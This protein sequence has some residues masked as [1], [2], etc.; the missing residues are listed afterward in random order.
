MQWD[1][2]HAEEPPQNVEQAPTTEPPASLLNQFNQFMFS[3]LFFD[4]LAGHLQ[5][6]G[7]AT[8]VPF[9]VVVLIFGGVFFT[10]WY[11]FINI[12]GFFHSITITRGKYDNKNDHGEITHFRALASALSATVGLGNIAGVAVAIQVGGP[13]VI[14]WMLCA[15][16]FGMSLKFSECTLAQMYRRVNADGSISGGPMYY[17]DLG[18]MA[19]GGLFKPFGKILAVTFAIMVMGGAIGGGNM[20]QANQSFEALATVLGHPEWLAA[21]ST[22]SW[23]FG[24]ILAFAVALVIIGGIK[25]IGAASSYIVPF[26]CGL[27]VIF[28]LFIIGSNYQQIPMA[29]LTI[30]DMAFTNDA[31]YGGFLGVL[32]MGFQRASFSNEAGLGSSSIAHAAA[33][34][35]EPIR[36]GLVA[37]LEPFIDTII[38]CLMT[39]LVVVITGAWNDPSVSSEAGV[40]LTSHAFA[41]A[42]SWFPYILTICVILFAYSTM[43]SWCYYGE[44]GWC[45]LL[46]HFGGRGLKTVLCFR[47][48]FV[49]AIVVGSVHPLKDVLDFADAMIL[50]MAFPNIV[51]SLMLAPTVLQRLKDYWHRYQSGAFD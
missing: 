9:L 3:I 20:F 30:F 35:E 13:G 26:M 34:T 15:A 39:A 49:I 46:D 37:M 31:A 8:A 23:I 24:C 14:F 12:R 29:L 21:G 38:V 17:L 28:S 50:S 43:L 7:K 2:L 6:D 19:K 22:P 47:V 48:L 4:I 5:I 45:Y 18:L 51:G 32:I 27:Y 11:R 33:K 25:R 36:E 10:F 40:A 42:A 44:R 1:Y 16:V 41:S